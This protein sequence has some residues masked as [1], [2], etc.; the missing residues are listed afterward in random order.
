MGLLVGMS[1]L[2]AVLIGLV[3][4]AE[5]FKRWWASESERAR[6]ER[7]E[8]AALRREIVDQAE[9]AMVRREKVLI[10]WRYPRDAEESAESPGPRIEYIQ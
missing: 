6:Q 5:W 3:A 8:E 1:G 2:M 9:F 7:A 10:P 4:L